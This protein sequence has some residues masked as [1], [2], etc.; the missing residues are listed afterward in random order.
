MRVRLC[1]CLC[2]SLSVSPDFLFSKILFDSISFLL[3]SIP[4][5]LLSHIKRFLPGIFFYLLFV[6]DIR[7]CYVHS[8]VC[9]RWAF[10]NIEFERRISVLEQFEIRRGSGEEALYLKVYFLWEECKD[11]FLGELPNRR[12]ANL[13]QTQRDSTAH[14]RP[15][16]A[17]RGTPSR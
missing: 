16:G 13:L 17:A 7:S 6:W 1:P 10:C 5:I 4:C 2:L 3:V 9:L 14:S 12:I 8:Y 15:R 11:F